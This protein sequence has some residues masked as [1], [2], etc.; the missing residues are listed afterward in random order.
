MCW[1]WCASPKALPVENLKPQVKVVV[2]KAEPP[3]GPVVIPPPEQEQK[4]VPQSEDKTPKTPTVTAPVLEPHSPQIATSPSP[5]DA[6]A[7]SSPSP[8]ANRIPVPVLSPRT[9]EMLEK[10]ARDNR[11]PLP[12]PIMLSLPIAKSPKS[13]MPSPKPRM[14]H[15]IPASTPPRKPPVP[16]ARSVSVPV[17]PPRE[18]SPTQKPAFLPR[19]TSGKI[20]PPRGLARRKFKEPVPQ[21]R[22]NINAPPTRKPALPSFEKAEGVITAQANA[23][24]RTRTTETRQQSPASAIRNARALQRSPVEKKTASRSASS[25]SPHKS[26]EMQGPPLLTRNERKME[27][28]DSQIAYFDAMRKA[29]I[30]TQREFRTR[31]AP[32]RK[33]FEELRALVEKER[34]RIVLEERLCQEEEEALAQAKLY[35]TPHNAGRKFRREPDTTTRELE[36]GPHNDPETVM[37]EESK[38]KQHSAEMGEL[39]MVEIN[40]NFTALGEDAEIEDTPASPHRTGRTARCDS[41][42]PTQGEFDDEDNAAE[43]SAVSPP[44]SSTDALL[45]L[46]QEKVPSPVQTMEEAGLQSPRSFRISSSETGQAQGRSVTPLTV[47]S[48][49]SEMADFDHAMAASRESPML[50]LSFASPQPPQIVSSTRFTSPDGKTSHSSPPA[51]FEPESAATTLGP[52]SIQASDSTATAQ[53]LQLTQQNYLPTTHQLPNTA[54][55]SLMLSTQSPF[56]PTPPESPIVTASAL[57]ESPKAQEPTHESAAASPP[58]AYNPFALEEEEPSRGVA[59]S[60]P[61][62]DSPTASPATQPPVTHASTAPRN[63]NRPPLH[64]SSSSPGI[65]SHTYRAST[66]SLPD[67]SPALQSSFASATSNSDWSTFDPSDSPFQD[68]TPANNTAHTAASVHI[69][70]HPAT[71]SSP[72]ILSSNAFAHF[73]VQSQAHPPQS[74]TEPKFNTLA[75]GAVGAAGY[76]ASAYGT[77]VSVQ[78]AQLAQGLH[79]LAG[80]GTIDL[81]SPSIG[82]AAQGHFQTSLSAQAKAIEAQAAEPEVIYPPTV[83]VTVANKTFAKGL[84]EPFLLVTPHPQKQ[85]Q[86]NKLSPTAPPTADTSLIWKDSQNIAN[87]HAAY[88]TYAQGQVVGSPT[89]AD[90]SPPKNTSKQS[91]VSSSTWNPDAEFGNSVNLMSIT[92]SLALHR[93]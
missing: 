23:F 63:A 70:S 50:T 67:R 75:T 87:I 43:L 81:P 2:V 71:A 61:L 21:T 59:I 12:V 40:D 41:L 65:A 36:Y 15:E 93:Q 33:E 14:N 42:Y 29:G 18:M 39:D 25:G 16:R 64:S 38:Q 31:V 28:L 24:A 32:L 57:A 66:D 37:Q 11:N 77:Y 88:G 86:P 48:V 73:P 6:I 84:P 82:S 8:L 89:H 58:S 44:D 51:T 30:M 46:E 68:N 20:T 47:G 55:V 60:A 76:A 74:M 85:Q 19:V 1:P 62:G 26:P 13:P 72:G 53:L 4:Q 78:G 79:A 49:D 90:Q 27:Q 69:S 92:Q 10:I 35:V 22:V 34:E 5:K 52:S 80:A 9:I 83:D 91:P 3:P 54:R 45:T 56:P 17:S 7:F